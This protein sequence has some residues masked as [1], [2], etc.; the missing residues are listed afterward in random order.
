MSR[1]C[2]AC[3]RPI[4]EE[5]VFC[6]ACG[7]RIEEAAA[8]AE[9]GSERP[10]PPVR[11]AR[12][13]LVVVAAAGFLTLLLVGLLGRHLEPAE[14][15]PRDCERLL[16]RARALS[17]D[18][19]PAEVARLLAPT[20]AATCGAEGRRLAAEALDEL[21]R[22]HARAGTVAV[23]A[24]RARELSLADDPGEPGALRAR[25]ELESRHGD[26]FVAWAWWEAA[27][28]AARERPLEGEAQAS[29]L[30]D[31]AVAAALAG[32]L[33]Q[34]DGLLEE[35]GRL[36]PSPS[37]VRLNRGLVALESGRRRSAKGHLEAAQRVRG[38]RAAA[39]A[40]LAEVARRSGDS[41]KARR[42]AGEALSADPENVQARH[43][44]AL[45]AR[46]RGQAETAARLLEE[47][48]ER[49]PDHPLLLEDLRRLRESR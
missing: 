35:A 39:L 23:R 3:H 37:V 14:D 12:V 16:S 36:R 28:E 26:R 32:R 34:A 22:R 20:G 38:L 48:L 19:S 7:V 1:P 29:L 47:A 2:P 5:A 6:P 42:E 46:D 8:R 4:D 17:G 13:R 15:P 18:G 11:E 10:A 27:V 21:S 31:A 33:V 41:S 25:A 43:V 49:A 24:L 9:R 30:N 44:L 45:I 40:G